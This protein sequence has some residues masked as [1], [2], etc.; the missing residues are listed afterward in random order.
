VSLHPP[1][2]QHIPIDATQDRVIRGFRAH[3]SGRQ[4][5]NTALSNTRMNALIP[6]HKIGIMGQPA[7]PTSACIG[8]TDNL[9]TS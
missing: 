1:T 4:S 7:A 3:L 5:V 2:D 9:D 6:Q 8:T